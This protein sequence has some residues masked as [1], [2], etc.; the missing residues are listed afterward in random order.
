METVRGGLDDVA[1]AL[2]ARERGYDLA[3][4]AME[5]LGVAAFVLGADGRVLLWNQAC[6]HLT[7][8]PARDVLGARNPWRA[9]YDKPR[10]CLAD[11]V[12]SQRADAVGSLYVR[13][14]ASARGGSA[15]SAETW[16]AM[17]QLG[18]PLYLTIDAAP[19]RDQSGAVIAVVE[20]L[21]DL[22]AD[23][24]RQEELE[25]LATLD[26]LTGLLNRRS[27]DERLGGEARRAARDQLPLALLMIDLDNFKPYNDAHGHQIGDACLKSVALAIRGALTRA[28]DLAARYG[29]DE[30]AVILPGVD[31]IG[32]ARVARRIRERVAALRIVNPFSANSYGLT[33]SV[34]GCAAA[35]DFVGSAS[36]LIATA[37]AELYRAKRSGRNRMSIV[38]CEAGAS[39]FGDHR[40]NPLAATGGRAA[41]GPNP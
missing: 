8:V 5:H 39:A 19:I 11:L 18:R 16:C 14:G 34:G 30:F 9:F 24:R 25:S 22:T 41:A 17:P 27:F 10:P 26:G 28:G 40:A 6:E 13:G 32:A 1:D 21:R 23:R 37:D 31:A 3:I 20:T 15:L 38:D 2:S 4:G 12:L 29:G 7:G 33:L 36:R 35:A